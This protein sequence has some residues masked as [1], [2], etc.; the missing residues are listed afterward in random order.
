MTQRCDAVGWDKFWRECEGRAYRGTSG[1]RHWHRAP[2]CTVNISTDGAST[3]SSGKLFHYWTRQTLKAWWR[4]RVFP[5]CWWI[6]K[7]WSWSL[8]RV[9][10]VK[11]APHRK[12]G[13]RVLYCTCIE[14][15]HGIMPLL[16]T[17]QFGNRPIRVCTYPRGHRQTCLTHITHTLC[18]NKFSRKQGGLGHCAIQIWGGAQD[19]AKGY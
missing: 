9:G 14:G 10:S 2:I 12:L 11:I 19:A 18:S 15:H 5:H 3:T 13:S 6:L 8:E 4:R 1:N 16:K 17:T 7:A